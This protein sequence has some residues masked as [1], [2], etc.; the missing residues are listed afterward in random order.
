MISNWTNLS[1]ILQGDISYNLSKTVTNTYVEFTLTAYGE[2]WTE[3]DIVFEYRIDEKSAWLEDAVITQTNAKY[4]RGN[5][6]YN[7]IASKDGYENMFLWSYFENNLLY[8]SIPQI[9][10]RILPR[11]RV[12]SNINGYCLIV[13]VYGDSL[14]NL[15]SLS[16]YEIVGINNSGEYMGIGSNVFYIVDDLSPESSSSSS[17]SSS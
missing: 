5:K 17:S 7:L 9:R 3:F 2:K 15:N 14:L 13:S 1:S 11:I 16:T 10:I 6:L 8:G 12:F 4:L